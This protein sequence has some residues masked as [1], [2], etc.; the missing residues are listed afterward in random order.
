METNHDTGDH[1]PLQS[2]AESFFAPPHDSLTIAFGGSSHVGKVRSQNEDHFAVFKRRRRTELLISNLPPDFLLPR[3]TCS[4]AMVVA[5]GMGGMKSG[6]VASRLALQKMVELS[7]LATSWVMRL[8]DMDAQ[9]MRHRVDAYVRQVHETLH[10]T[11]KSSPALEDMGTT[12]TS[13]HFLGASVVIVHIGDSRAYLYCQDQ[14]HQI[15]HDETMAQA[16]VD[17]GCAAESVK[18]FRHVLLNS[19]GGGNA[20]ASAAIHLIELEPNDRLLLCT[21]GLSDMVSDEDIAAEL[22]RRENPQSACDALVQRALENGGRDNVTVVLAI[23][24]EASD[25]TD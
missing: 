10:M 16:L 4:F 9:Q 21:D 23:A 13:A 5:D 3:E 20:M 17:S 19:L 24:S 12:W 14:L 6:E 18:K 7:G 8:T 11:G 15:T 1:V 22:Q 25:A 2:F